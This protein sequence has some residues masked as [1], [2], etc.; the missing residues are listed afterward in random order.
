MSQALQQLI[1]YT[2]EDDISSELENPNEEVLKLEQFNGLNRKAVAL[3]A[4]PI[5]VSLNK[6]IENGIWVLVAMF[7]KCNN[8]KSISQGSVGIVKAGYKI[9]C[10]CIQSKEKLENMISYTGDGIVYYKQLQTLGNAQFKDGQQITLELNMEAGTLRFLV[11]GIP[12]IVNIRGIKEPVK[13]QCE[14]KN[15][16]S[17]FVILQFRKVST[18]ILKSG[19]NEKSINW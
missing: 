11:E 10:P 15:L 8:A 3:K 12:Q 4:Q 16:N 19:L 6:V 1:K 13:F 9:P 2:A 17:S 5:V 14:I 18:P 7:D